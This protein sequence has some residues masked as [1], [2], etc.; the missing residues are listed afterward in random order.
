MEQVQEEREGKE[1][2]K[3][4]GGGG[5][6]LVTR[7]MKSQHKNSSKDAKGVVHESQ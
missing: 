7:V 3:K 6:A 2:Q 5:E 4:E 1:E